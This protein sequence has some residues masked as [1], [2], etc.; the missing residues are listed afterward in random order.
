MIHVAGGA[1][2]HGFY[3]DTHAD[4]VPEALYALVEQALASAPN[5]PVLLERDGAFSAPD[6]IFGELDRLRTLPRPT[7]RQRAERCARVAVATPTTAL[8][9]AQCALAERLTNEPQAGEPLA[10]ARTRRV[11]AKK[12][13]E[14][15][16]DLLPSLG[17]RLSSEEAARLGR[18][19][20][21]A[22]RS[23]PFVG[24]ERMGDRA[25]WAVKG[26]GRGARVHLLEVAQQEE[27][28]DEPTL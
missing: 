19:V 24:R 17:A 26:F 20:L 8:D 21:R 3:F 5:A 15:A 23:L 18:L 7:P 10:I 9:D 11:L 25:V 14:A 13:A 27:T 16:L 22:R 1:F 4:P 12:R 2:D 28:A 6:E